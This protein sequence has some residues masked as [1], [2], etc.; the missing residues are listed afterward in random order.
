MG[1]T[2]IRQRVAAFNGEFTVCSEPGKG[3]ESNIELR[4]E[5]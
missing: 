4:V 2:N 5:N 1:L 3:T